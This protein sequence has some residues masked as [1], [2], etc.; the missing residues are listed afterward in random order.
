MWNI[1][2]VNVVGEH[3]SLKRDGAYL[4]YLICLCI[5]CWRQDSVMVVIQWRAI[6]IECRQMSCDVVIMSR[7]S[8]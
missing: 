4:G 8:E 7:G 6:A 2:V 5:Y 1:G 3:Q